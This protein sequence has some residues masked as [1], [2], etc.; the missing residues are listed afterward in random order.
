ML[1]IFN[2]SSKQMMALRDSKVLYGFVVSFATQM[3]D[4]FLLGLGLDLFLKSG[5]VPR[6][7]TPKVRDRLSNE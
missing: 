7:E 6:N 5:T 4:I 2:D 1:T 3:F